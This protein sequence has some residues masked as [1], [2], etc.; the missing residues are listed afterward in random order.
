MI[1]VELTFTFS[2]IN[3]VLFISGSK[4]RWLKPLL[5]N[6]LSCTSWRCVVVQRNVFTT[7]CSRGQLRLTK[8]SGSCRGHSVRHFSF[9]AF[10]RCGRDR[11]T[12]VAARRP[13]ILFIDL[14]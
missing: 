11:F 13:A 8:R 6:N 1:F 4:V 9:A 7:F 5:L 14:L 3:S 2:K 12:F 10:R